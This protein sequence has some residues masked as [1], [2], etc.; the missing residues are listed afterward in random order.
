MSHSR[1][2]KLFAIAVCVILLI[3]LLFGPPFTV[4][5]VRLKLR[6]NSILSIAPSRAVRSWHSKYDGQKFPAGI[7]AYDES[8]RCYGVEVDSTRT[9]LILS[10]T[11]DREFYKMNDPA[12][13][14]ELWNRSTKIR[15]QLVK[16]YPQ[17]FP[18][19]SIKTDAKSR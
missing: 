1:L 11:Y 19:E 5:I 13:I 8:K 15:E 12:L 10:T 14:E 7:W 2:F 9:T 3:Y 16:E 6:D 18:D 17:E 4:R